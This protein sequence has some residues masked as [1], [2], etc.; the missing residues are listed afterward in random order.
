MPLSSLG[1]G[2]PS[3]PDLSQAEQFL[4]A[5][6]LGIEFWVD[7]SERLRKLTVSASMRIYPSTPG[8]A[9]TESA[10]QLPITVT[11]TFDVSNYGAPVDVTP[12]PGNEVTP[13]DACQGD[14]GGFS[15]QP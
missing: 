1:G 2:R 14:T 6:S 9:T 4:G 8:T 15:C 12:P 3:A 11:E 7:S 5:A 13:G 10:S